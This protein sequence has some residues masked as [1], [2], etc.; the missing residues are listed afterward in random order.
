MPSPAGQFTEEQLAEL[1]KAIKHQV[2][3]LGV[4]PYPMTPWTH[5]LWFACPIAH[6]VNM[7]SLLLPRHTLQV[8]SLV[9]QLVKE[10][11]VAVP[12][13]IKPEQ[14]LQVLQERGVVENL[15]SKLTAPAP[16]TL[17]AQAAA[18]ESAYLPAK[19]APPATR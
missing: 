7:R 13:P 11:H 4:R 19:A 14:A 12:G 3:N 8:G 10:L 18:S 15:A 2:K 1:R 9:E 16:L 5:G 17:G 6:D